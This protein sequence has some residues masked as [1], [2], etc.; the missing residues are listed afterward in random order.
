M[1]K[2]GVYAVKVFYKNISYDGMANIGV[3]PTFNAKEA[4]P[5]I[6]VNIFDYN[7][8]LYGELLKVEWHKFIREEKKF[9]GIDEL[10]NQIKQDEEAIRAYFQ[11]GR[12]A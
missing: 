2:F 9:N 10:V 6:E 5:S 4:E 1:F 8:D 11:T 12:K 7:H 3:K